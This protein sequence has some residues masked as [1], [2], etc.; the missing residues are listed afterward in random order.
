MAL[1]IVTVNVSQVAAP[2]PSTLQRTGAFISQGGTTGA[3]GSLALLTDLS[4]LTAITPAAKAL[5]SLTWT[6]MVVTATTTAPHGWANGT[7]FP[8]T[9][10]GCAP[11]GY[12]GVY[13]ATVTGA[14]TLTYPLTANPGSIVTSGTVTPYSVAEI[15]AMA[16]TFFAQGSSASVYVLELGI[17]T[18]A[19]GVTALGTFIT[20]NPGTVY[21]YLVPRSWSDEAT[22]IT[23]V[24]TLTATTAK[25]YFFTTAT[26]S[27]YD[28]FGPTLKSVALFIEAPT[29]ANPEFSAAA[30]FYAWINNN[31]SPSNKVAPMAYRYLFGV[32]PYPTVGNA[33]LRTTLK[34]AGVNI[35]GTGA[36]GGVSTSILLWGT[37]MDGNDMTYW[38]SVDW[39]QINID[40]DLANEIING[41]N[42][43]Q[44]P[45]YYNQDGINRLEARAQTTMNAGVSDGLV[46]GNPQ[47]TATSFVTYVAANPS[48]Y[49]DGIYNGLAVT[50]TPQLGFKSITFYVQVSSIPVAS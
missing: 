1:N 26:T 48:D 45:L 25:T 6:T 31:P 30:P 20:A 15:D 33:A 22:F 40:L 21:S 23:Y 9:I 47:V 38:Y 49:A 7:V 8:V 34:A 50:Y 4:D 16:T 5:T 27:N 19:A 42:N 41:S 37:M 36:E 13:T 3:V 39:V 32:T 17:G 46:L 44:A 24:G 35:I 14:S 28:D 11:A 18:P 12:N 43:P 2:A 10:A 29:V